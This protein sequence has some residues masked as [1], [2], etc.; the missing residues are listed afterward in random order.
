[1]SEE[2][3]VQGRAGT[4]SGTVEGRVAE[5]A[6]AQASPL[7]LAV[8]EVTVTL[9]QPPVV[10]IVVDVDVPAEGRIADAQARPAAVDIDAIAQLSRSLGETLTTAGMTPDDATLEVS[11]PG[12]DRPL[13]DAHDLVR[14]LGRDVDVHL[15]DEGSPAV[16]GRLVAV[17]GDMLE[18]I[19]AGQ[20][21]GSSGTR[22]LELAQVAY[23]LPVLPW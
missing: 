17:E 5:L 7:G 8:L 6:V 20:R 21:V 1:V 11:S 13:R 23:A 16:R 14:N 4:A 22:R 18:L 12:A 19:P 10:R 15:Q 3:R 9:Q 2:R